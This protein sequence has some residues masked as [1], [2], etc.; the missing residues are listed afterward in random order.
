MGVCDLTLSI[1]NDKLL[2]YKKYMNDCSDN[3]KCIATYM[4]LFFANKKAKK[5]L[6]Y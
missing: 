4:N 2:L 3:C 1:I 6:S 5:Y